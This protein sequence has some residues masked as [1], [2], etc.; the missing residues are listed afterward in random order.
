ML[1]PCLIFP[2]SNV[3]PDFRDLRIP[4]S[5]YTRVPPTTLAPLPLHRGP[6]SN[7]ATRS[8]PFPFLRVLL[9]LQ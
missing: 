6:D 5:F 2:D 9:E 3:L 1:V 8:P 4:D 7:G